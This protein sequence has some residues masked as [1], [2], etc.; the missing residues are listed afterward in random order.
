MHI[1]LASHKKK[2]EQNKTKQRLQPVKNSTARLL[3]KIEKREHISQLWDILPIDIR[4]T[5]LLF[6]FLKKVISSNQPTSPSF[7]H[8]SGFYFPSDLLGCIFASF[9]I[10]V[11]WGYSIE[12]HGKMSE[13]NDINQQRK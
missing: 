13:G 6:L 12:D 10:V 11:K 2:E 4:E 5:S 8:R 7:L 9:L 3:T 1:S